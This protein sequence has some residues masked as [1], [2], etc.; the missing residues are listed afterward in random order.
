MTTH[1]SPFTP[2]Q[3]GTGAIRFP[4]GVTIPTSADAAVD[5][6]FKTRVPKD[7]QVEAIYYWPQEKGVYPGIV[8][9]HE[10]WGLTSQIKDVALRLACEGYGVLIPNL[11]TRVGGMVTASAEIAEALMGRLNEAAVLQDINSCCEYFN[12]REFLKRN[13]HAVIGFGMGGSLAIHFACQRKRL[14]AAVAYYGLLRDRQNRVSELHCPLLYHQAEADS[15]V[16]A[17]EVEQLRRATASQGKPVEIKRYQGT[18]HGFSNEMRKD[19]YHSEASQQAWDATLA[20]LAEH[21]RA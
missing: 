20:F 19:A 21:L 2:Q 5:P 1:V 15:L 11:Y 14:R 3:V 9:L 7:I 16:S 18:S 10:W 6:Y 4:S 13:I 8:L 17:D 12:T